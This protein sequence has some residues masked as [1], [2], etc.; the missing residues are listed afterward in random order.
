M[1]LRRTL[2]SNRAQQ[3][4]GLRSFEPLRASQD[5][6]AFLSRCVFNTLFSRCV[7]AHQSP[8]TVR[9]HAAL[10]LVRLIATAKA[11][12]MLVPNEPE[13][14]FSIGNG[15]EAAPPAGNPF[16]VDNVSSE[17]VSLPASGRYKP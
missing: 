10:L 7:S 11:L 12:S 16:P 3:S 8:A 1:T 14:G 17:F 4:G 15:R 13:D 9:E 5:D 6:N 2:S